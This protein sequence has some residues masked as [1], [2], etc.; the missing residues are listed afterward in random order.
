MDESFGNSS[1][2]YSP[3]KNKC[4]NRTNFPNESFT[5]LCVANNSKVLDGAITFEYNGSRKGES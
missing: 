4:T 2:P 5:I 1:V 3:P